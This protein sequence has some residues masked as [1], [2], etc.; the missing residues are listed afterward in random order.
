MALVIFLLLKIHMLLE[1]IF[2]PF[3]V[4]V[5]MGKSNQLLV[6]LFP[7]LH[8]RSDLIILFFNFKIIFLN[9]FSDPTL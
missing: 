2:V 4:C 1:K 7:D 8:E 9:V 5:G 6:S 3:H